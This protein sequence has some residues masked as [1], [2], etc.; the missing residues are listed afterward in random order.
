[1]RCAMKITC[2]NSAPFPFHVH[3]KP[4]V[5]VSQEEEHRA[6]IRGAFCGCQAPNLA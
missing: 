2:E 4:H 1:M 3:T 6:Q 5:P